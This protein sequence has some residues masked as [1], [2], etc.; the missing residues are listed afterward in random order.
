MYRERLELTD[1]VAVVTGGARGIG[2]AAATALHELGATVVL[3]DIL[4]ELGAKAAASFAAGGPPIEYLHL[5]VR[6][7]QAVGAALDTVVD[8]FGALDVVVTSAGVASHTPA[9]EV[10]PDEWQRVLDVNLNGSFWCARE[11]GRRMGA[12][13]S[14]VAIGSMSGEVAN[15][16]QAQAAYNAS[17]GGVHLMVRSLAVEFAQSGIRIN[18]VAPGYVATELTSEGVPADWI[19]DWRR[20]TPMDRLARPEEVASVVAFL[21][22]EAASYMTGSVVLVDGGYTTW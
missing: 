13:G 3:A 4:D 8:R 22:S 17:K 18:A 11:A 7:H 21:A 5:D 19:A 1:K 10:T 9:L 12:G 14:I 6:D 15:A 20:R 2:L 16:P